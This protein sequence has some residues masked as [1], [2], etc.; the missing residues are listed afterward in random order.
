MAFQTRP[1][2]FRL[3]PFAR[4]Q[5]EWQLFLFVNLKNQTREAVFCIQFSMSPMISRKTT[6]RK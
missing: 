6:L 2:T 4:I 3:Q 1:S 5:K